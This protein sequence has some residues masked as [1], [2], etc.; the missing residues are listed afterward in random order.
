[1]DFEWDRAK[2]DGNLTKHGIDFVEALDVFNDTE[3]LIVV[4]RHR[5]NELWY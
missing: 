4:D 2:A 1:M 5:Y 3:L